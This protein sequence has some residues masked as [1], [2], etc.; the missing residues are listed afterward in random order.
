M[1]NF[2]M[3]L[4]EEHRIIENSFGAFIQKRRRGKAY[5]GGASKS[6]WRTLSMHP[7]LEEALQAWE[8][9]PTPQTA[10]LPPSEAQEIPFQEG[11][12]SVIDLNGRAF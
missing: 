3:K 1:D 8:V 6:V 12:Y 9:P 4:D 2:L 10:A 5:S 7:G 11:G